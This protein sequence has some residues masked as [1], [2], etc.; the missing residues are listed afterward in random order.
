[1][2][3]IPSYSGSPGSSEAQEA[4]YESPDISP[5]KCETSQQPK[6]EASGTVEEC[7]VCRNEMIDTCTLSDCVHEF[8]Y[9]CIIGWLTK[10]AGPFCPMCKAPVKYITKKGTNEKIT[11]EQIKVN[12]EPAPTASADLIT[13]KRIVSR[14]IRSCRRLM[15]RIDEIIGATSGRSE[16]QK[17][18]E[19][20][21]EL[22]F[23]K[24]KCVAQLNALQM[25][26][27]DIDH[28]A[29]KA[30]IVSRVE[31]R[32]LIYERS[33]I[34]ERLPTEFVMISKEEIVADIEHYRAV[35]HSF[36]NIELKALP[37]K[38]QPK[39]D[40]ENLWH[41]KTLPDVA[42]DQLD[43][44]VSRIFSLVLEVG[45]AD[46]RHDHILEA[47]NGLIS[48]RVA[49]E[50][51]AE[52]ASLVNSKKSF[53]DWCGSVTYRSRMDRGGE[54]GNQN[55]VVI[56]NDDDLEDEPNE[57]EPVR[58]RPVF[59][60]FDQIF[61]QPSNRDFGNRRSS[62]D[63]DED[64]DIYFQAPLRIGPFG[65]NPY[66]APPHPLFPP[67]PAAGPSW[68]DLTRPSGTSKRTTRKKKEISPSGAPVVCLGDEREI[69]RRP[70]D[71]G[72]DNEIQVVEQDNT[73]VLD[74]SID[75]RSERVGTD[76]TS[77]KRHAEEKLKYDS[78]RTKS[79]SLPEGLVSDI[80]EL[81]IKYKLPITGGVDML[82][83]ASQ[84][85]FIEVLKPPPVP[86][87]NLSE[88]LLE[89]SSSSVMDPSIA[90]FSDIARNGFGLPPRNGPPTSNY[91][92]H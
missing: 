70:S 26:R 15:N 24:Q 54:S 17:R 48:Y 25:L 37:A 67:I 73:I 85:A 65:F 30:L 71:S 22:N 74:D 53:L 7:S 57:I 64:E 72:S 52:L 58:H 23:M 92:Y 49:G 51:I 91:G 68:M 45:I 27:E 31:F 50:F 88:A 14:K 18:K 3:D 79:Y 86:P 16:S 12:T 75:N 63:S 4:K 20:I 34:S 69:K 9:E 36:L 40:K 19:R 29:A 41:F 44:F 87:K 83:E 47:L 61:A 8:C 35:L 43:E 62:S 32:R 38:T 28:G 39:V 59:T 46:L 2:D 11:L 84:K 21:E 76:A 66:R 90:S 10:G 82:N 55:E 81:I 42:Q 5:E 77:R 80:K 89:S 78:K 13:E 56:V 6:E 33:V 1:M 60:P